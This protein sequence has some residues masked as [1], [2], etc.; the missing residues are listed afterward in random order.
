MPFDLRREQLDVRI[1]ALSDEHHIVA[2][3]DNWCLV[4]SVIVS[5]KLEISLINLCHQYL[6]D[7]GICNIWKSVWILISCVSRAT[8]NPRIPMVT[9]LKYPSSKF[10]SVLGYWSTYLFWYQ[11][12]QAIILSDFFSGIGAFLFCI[13]ADILVIWCTE[14][15]TP[16]C[17]KVVLLSGL[18]GCLVM[19]MLWGSRQRLKYLKLSVILVA[20][21]GNMSCPMGSVHHG[22]FFA[23]PR[24]E[25]VSFTMAGRKS[26]SSG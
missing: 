2:N 7:R 21:W 8:Q 9:L 3:F 22:W 10:E 13:L 26:R 11:P 12:L 5:G 23:A 15:S 6:Y 16:F 24:S 17:C 1:L 18:Y 19:L 20:W 25:W 14:L 4:I